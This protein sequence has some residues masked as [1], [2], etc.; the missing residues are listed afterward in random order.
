MSKNNKKNTKNNNSTNI[1]SYTG[2]GHNDV[3]F[4]CYIATPLHL[5]QTE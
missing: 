5:R 2:E 1:I 3:T 4:Q